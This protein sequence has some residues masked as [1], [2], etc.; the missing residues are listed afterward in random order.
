MD[1]VEEKTFLQE[2]DEALA[3]ITHIDARKHRKTITAAVADV[4]FSI[5]FE[6]LNWEIF[7]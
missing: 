2:R 7:E 5:N 6:I 1:D 4:K 3:T